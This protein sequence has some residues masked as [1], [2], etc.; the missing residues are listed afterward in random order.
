[1]SSR[2]RV[3]G[4][5]VASLGLM[6]AVAATACGSAKP[7]HPLALPAARDLAPSASS[8]VIVIVMENREYSQVIGNRSAPYINRLARSS[9]VA[10]RYFAIAH[11]SLPNYL[12]LTGGQTFGI[13]SDCTDCVARGTSLADQ[14]AGAG[15]S[16]GVYIEDLPGP[17]SKASFAGGYAKKHDPFMYFPSIADDPGRCGHVVPLTQLPRDLAA[18][19][20]P[21][22]VWITPNL[23]DDGHDCPLSSADRFLA[24]TLPPLLSQLGP[25]GFLALTWDEDTSGRGCCRLAHG[26]QVVTLL[27]GPQ[28]RRGTRAGGPFD[29]YSLLRTIEDALGVSHL[30]S[31]GCS[32]T[33]PLDSLFRVA[34]RHIE[35][36][37]KPA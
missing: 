2:L 6:L 34:P 1:M 3:I 36:A 7:G 28:V 8:H 11:P 26:G 23:C 25:R 18:G 14:L 29:H 35:A 30:A 17:C 32:C 33:R 13:D 31:A 10:S 37:R 16:W 15:R 21:D 5:G 12:A 19:R 27:N 4:G 22:F 9:A 20:L 24:H